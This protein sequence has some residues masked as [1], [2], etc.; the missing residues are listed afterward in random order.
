MP[1]R[2]EELGTIARSWMSV[3]GLAEATSR[4]R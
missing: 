2:K 1:S 3:E 4:A